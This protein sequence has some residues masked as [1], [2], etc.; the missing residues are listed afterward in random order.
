MRRA[1][2]V[3]LVIAGPAIVAVGYLHVPSASSCAMAN[4]IALDLGKPPTCSTTPSSLYF[5][6]AAA[7]VIA[8]LLVAMPW[9]RWLTGTN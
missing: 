8:G 1:L 4:G 2:G 7:L 5:I 3:L 6:V 9:S